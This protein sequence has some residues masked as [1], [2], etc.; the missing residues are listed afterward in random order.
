L[1]ET[2]NP[3]R[4]IKSPAWGGVSE[5]MDK[6]RRLYLRTHSKREVNTQSCM[7][8]CAPLLR[9]TCSRKGLG[10]AHTRSPAWLNCHNMAAVKWL[11]QWWLG[12]VRCFSLEFLDFTLNPEITWIKFM[13]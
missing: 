10:S 13:S 6:N 1:V 4:K 3:L 8:R 11:L 9:C 5:M 7:H 12:F 2:N